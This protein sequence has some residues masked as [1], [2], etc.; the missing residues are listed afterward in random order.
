MSESVFDKTFDIEIA[1]TQLSLSGDY[2]IFFVSKTV[3]YV[4]SEAIDEQ[5]SGMGKFLFAQHRHLLN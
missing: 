4:A 3:D 2:S 5:L 1:K